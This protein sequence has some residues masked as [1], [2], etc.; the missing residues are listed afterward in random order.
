MA[1][2]RKSRRA[3]TLKKGWYVTER[4][5][6]KFQLFFKD[7]N[8]N[9]QRPLFDTLE[10]AKATLIAIEAQIKKGG[11]LASA[12]HRTFGEALDLLLEYSR[13]HHQGSSIRRIKSVVVTLRKQFGRR[14][15]SEF[16]ANQNKFV[17][18]WLIELSET[19]T[20][21][22]P[23]GRQLQTL[24]HYKSA[25]K[26]SLSLAIKEGWMAAPNPFNEFEF[27]LPDVGSEETK[28]L[29]LDEIENALLIC[30]VRDPAEHE[31]VFR[32]RDLFLRIGLLQGTRPGETC[33]LCLDMI[34]LDAR[35][36][37]ITRKVAINK[38][39]DR[40]ELMEGTKTT[41]RGKR[42]AGKRELPMGLA[43]H[44]ALVEYID[45]LRELGLPTE[46]RV[47][48]L[49]TDQKELVAPDYISEHLFPSIRDKV[50][51]PAGLIAYSLRTSFANMLRVIG[52]SI[53]RVMVMMGHNN[54]ATT[55]KD[56]YR[57]T[58]SYEPLIDG[59]KEMAAKF[60]L[61]L[62]KNAD[63]I[64]AL[65]LEL[66]YRVH[67]RAKAQNVETNFR[68][69]DLRQ[70]A[71]SRFGNQHQINGPATL[72][73]PGNVLDLVANNSIEV[74]AFSSK[75]SLHTLTHKQDQRAYAI[76]RYL[77]GIPKQEIK[78]ELGIAAITLDKWLRA[79]GFPEV[80]IGR[81]KQQ[82]EK[83]LRAAVAA[84]REHTDDSAEIG[85][86]TGLEP[87][88]AAR[89]ERE[90]GHPMPHRP[91][92]HKVGKF[93]AEIDEIRAAGTKDNR[94]VVAI[95]QKRHPGEKIPAHSSIG[96]F[97]KRRREAAAVSKNHQTGRELGEAP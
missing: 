36:L 87:D 85:R 28:P 93:E 15:L 82:E 41:K 61:D 95:L 4:A 56:Y 68:C 42:D 69:S 47:Q 83:A 30:S 43:V 49:R 60:K 1:K 20:K 5:D 24:A 39:T 7:T 14:K 58:P 51:L 9:P 8:G 11:Y 78:E 74:G 92:A 38:K 91:G 94:K 88:R 73:L 59:V 18:D 33:A 53:E 37:W 63:A 26:L 71:P 72:A 44:V 2:K 46:G 86:M 84:A 76:K 3:S 40:Y 19:P 34:N 55:S 29:T 62:D 65:T 89:Y 6:G 48:L 75:Q 96:A 70:P 77:A 23:K 22:A 27:K 67:T 16:W 90:R 17:Y 79:A 81:L 52:V 32:A 80:K 10:E 54:I 64:D 12:A 13:L 66:A 50:G 97:L 35:K 21:R 57:D 25:C 45:R 31:M